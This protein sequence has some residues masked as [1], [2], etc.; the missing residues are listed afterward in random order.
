MAETL[1]SIRQRVAFVL[2]DEGNHLSAGQGEDLD[3]VIRESLETLSHDLP[4]EIVADIAGDGTTYDLTLPAT[5]VDGFS[6]IVS[7][8][9]PAGER[10]AVYLDPN[11]YRIYRTASSTK[12]RLDE[13]T[14]ASGESARV[15]LTGLHTLDDLD[16]ATAT[17][18]PTYHTQAFVTLCAATALYRLAAKFLH[19]QESS[20]NA[21]AVDRRSKADEARRLGDKLLARYRDQIGAARGEAPAL[22]VRDWDY[23]Q[24]RGAYGLTHR[25][26]TI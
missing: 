21:D 6:R 20:F 13:T 19:E 24:H 25:R 14:P 26:G 18:V 22:L 15:T 8:E 16:S 17:T 5:Y 1:E 23:P 12:L 2:L 10:P 9:Y 4:R 3:S 7:V 11:E